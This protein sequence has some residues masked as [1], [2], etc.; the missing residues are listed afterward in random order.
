MKTVLVITD[1]TRMKEGR[2]CIAGYD[3]TGRCVRPVLPPPG[4]Q[5]RSLH[6]KDRVVVCP[7]ARVEYDLVEPLPRPPHTEDHR[8]DPTSVRFVGR[9][10]RR[11]W[12]RALSRTLFKSVEAI[13]EQPIITD[14]GYS[15]MD[16]RGV[17]SLGTIRPRQVAKVVHEQDSAG[18]W[19]YRLGFVDGGGSRYWLT[20]T[21][22]A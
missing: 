11:Q 7:S 8:Y 20:V 2:V 17:R 5:E 12:N 19:K 18:E 16:G 15:V 10:N 21:D 13:F 3:A 4:V 1:V 14:T 9:L 6:T 22:L